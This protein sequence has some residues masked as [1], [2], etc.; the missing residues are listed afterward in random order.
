[1]GSSNS[2]S[3][4]VIGTP[5]SAAFG[6][7]RFDSPGKS[8]LIQ[9]QL[10]YRGH[11]A[12][13]TSSFSSSTALSSTS[14]LAHSER[15]QII[16]AKPTTSTTTTATEQSSL[17]LP[18]KEDDQR[19]VLLQQEEEPSSFSTLPSPPALLVWIGPALSCALCYALYNIFIKKGSSHISPILGGVI[20]QLVAVL[21]GSALLLYLLLT[22]SERTTNEDAT[23]VW[24]DDQENHYYTEFSNHTGAAVSA[25]LSPAE[26]LLA[27]NST[28]LMWAILAGVAVGAAEM[29]S[30][31]VSSL[32]VQAMQSIPIIVGGSVLMGTVMGWLLL[33]EQ[34]TMVGWSGV[35]LISMGIALVGLDAPAD[36]HH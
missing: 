26:S 36:S 13:V 15:Q 19:R 31:F 20:L 22:T 24:G 34:L 32:G 30:F 33:G 18:K 4:A 29:I 7:L 35:V 28:G 17:L 21:F 12:A 25:S 5:S 9:R 14:R 16:K 2:K 23:N 8:P 1:M 10:S 27:W 6:R 3:T 11:G